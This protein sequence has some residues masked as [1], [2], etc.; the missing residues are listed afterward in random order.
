MGRKVKPWIVL[1]F[2]LPGL[3][4]FTYFELIPLGFSFY[5]SL[6]DWN[7]FSSDK[8][9]VGL[10][11]FKELFQDESFKVA[12]GNTLFYLVLGGVVVFG[13]AIWFT[14]LLTKKN[15]KGQQLFS[16]F[17]YFPNMVSPAALA[18]LWVFFYNPSFGLLS[19]ILQKLNFEN[20]AY[21][22]LGTRTSA[23]IC[24]TLAACISNVGFYLILLLSGA[25]RIPPDY[26]EAAS[27][28][29]AGNI[30]TFI[31]VTLPLMRNV[32][33]IAVSLWIINS[34]K[35]FELIWA[36]FRGLTQYTQTLAT[37]M[38]TVAFGAQL[39]I[40]KLGYGSAIAVIMFLIVFVGVGLFRRIFDRDDLQY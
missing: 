35:Y 31:K 29:G 3:V 4:L 27:L 25:N 1:S 13:L 39:P 37:Y 34:V 16:N 19:G 32:I 14:Y 22:W 6:T 7:G 40:F 26:L 5:N 12:I 8:T 15:F 38:Y 28:D 11:N 17:F 36:M 10:S 2:L 33:I 9:F 18:V 30:I 24:I 21:S 20:Y 23:M